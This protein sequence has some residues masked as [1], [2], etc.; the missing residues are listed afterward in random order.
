MA[1]RKQEETKEEEK[2]PEIPTKVMPF[3]DM[4]LTF[5]TTQ[6]AYREEVSM[7]LANYT[8]DLRLGNLS[9]LPGGELDF[10]RAWLRIMNICEYMGLTNAQ[11][12][13]YGMVI[14]V[15]ET[16][17]SKGGFLRKRHGT[18]TAEKIDSSGQ[19]KILGGKKEE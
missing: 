14:S 12:A 7:R 5:L 6:P 10:C 17:Q 19:R 16:S 2:F 4:E 3:N 15:T 18:I 13:S 8:R 11:L 9:N 1:N